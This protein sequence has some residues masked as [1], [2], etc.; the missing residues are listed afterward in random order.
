MAANPEVNNVV[1]GAATYSPFEVVRR[2]DFPC[3]AWLCELSADLSVHCGSHV[4]VFDNGLVEGCWDGPFGAF[5]FLGCP[6]FFGSGVVKSGGVTWFCPP[7]HTV[8]CLYAMRHRDR[9]L[10]SNS[11][12]LLFRE[13]GAPLNLSYNYTEKLVTI[14][15]GIDASET[16]IYDSIDTTFYRVTYDDFRFDGGV[17]KRRRKRMP[18]GFADFGEYRRYLLDTIAACTRNADDPQ[19]GW[20]YQLLASC[21]SGYDSNAGAALAA[22]V[23]CRRAISLRSGRG[24]GADSGRP[25]AEILGLACV[26]RERCGRPSGDMFREVE[27]LMAGSGGADYPLSAFEDELA[28]ALLLT[29]YHAEAIWDSRARPTGAL[30]RVGNTGCSLAE[31][32]LRVGFL[33]MPV[34]AIGALRDSDVITRGRSSEMPPFSIGGDYARPIP[35]RIL[36]EAG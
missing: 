23:G 19:R 12:M 20:R 22:Q 10:V 32:R 35:R 21:S 3:L 17:V 15:N 1:N 25:V 18:A 26:E 27:F 30:A 28:G 16:I 4:E 14:T 29:G 2:R 34:P 9:F 11:L 33:H 5:D 7:C 24:G 31:I 13:S 8:D 6:N 36:E